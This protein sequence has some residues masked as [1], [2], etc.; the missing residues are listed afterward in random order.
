M[1]PLI[2]IIIPVYN[3]AK[4]L[5]LALDSIQKQTYR[6]LEVIVVDDGS[7]AKFS[8][9]NFSASP[10]GR[11]FSI[12]LPVQFVRQENTGAPAARNRGLEM[13]K[14][15]YVIF[16]D[17]DIVGRPEMLEKLKKK[18][19]EH[20]EANFAYCNYLL[21]LVSYLPAK[22]MPAREFDIGELKKNNYIHST[23]LIRRKDAIKW[24]ESL[25]RFQ[26]WDL[27]LT[28]AEQGKTGVLVDEYLFKII[29]QGTMSR[30]LPSF[31]YKK[32]FSWLPFVS[33]RVREYN[34]A[35]AIVSKKHRTRI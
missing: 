29:S 1:Q 28:M 32:P 10:A 31:C 27:W 24:D 30:W 5:R 16:W 33:K 8:I 13:A 35:K 11:Q 34:E 4:E 20:P 23:S 9:F 22:K 7:K 15:E 14:G 17:A 2:S 18:L 19:N 3:Q 21:S 25:K 26:D 12:D 6:N